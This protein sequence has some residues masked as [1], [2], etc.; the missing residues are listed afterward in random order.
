MFEK[1][2][3]VMTCSRDLSGMAELFPNIEYAAP[4]GVSLTLDLLCPWQKNRRYP[5]VVFVQGSAWTTPNTG[6]E[7]P[8]LGALA[9]QGFVVA[10]VGHRDCRKGNPFP[11]YLQDV[12]TAIRF[13]RAH[14]DEF[15]IDKERVG[16]WG[17]SSG[18]NTALLVG[19]TGDW[20]CY[21]TEDYPEESDRV[22]LVVECFGPTDLRELI[23]V[24]MGIDIEQLEHFDPAEVS[25][26]SAQLA[27]NA[28]LAGLICDETGKISPE[29]VWQMSP[30]MLADPDREYPPF[31]LLHGDAD[32]VVPYHQTEKLFEKLRGFGYDAEMV[33]VAGG[34]HEDIFWTPELVEYVWKYLK[35]RL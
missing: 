28:E 22:K 11:A 16:I 13:L 12:K 30:L 14:A 24:R 35:E 1:E 21:R 19:M 33:R 6:Y 15:C 26:E 34:V 2:V 10:T 8:Q 17:T 9:Q 3:K 23:Q 5:L 32:P 27:A 18:G 29:K 31:L 20:D 4:Q 7:M 25:S